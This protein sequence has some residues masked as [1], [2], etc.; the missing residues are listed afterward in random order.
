[1]PDLGG[2]RRL[3]L[4]DLDQE[5]LEGL[6]RHGEDL[7]VERK[8][9]L[10]RP[11]GFGAAAGSFANT[12]GGWILLGIADDGTVVGWEKPERLDLQSHLGNVLRAQVDPLPPF[13]AAMREVDGK[14]VAVVRVFPS[15]DLP[16]IARGTGAVHVRS[17]GGREPV[18]DH[19]TLLELARRGDDAEARARRRLAELDGVGMALRPPDF[20]PG[21]V[22]FAD[23]VDVRF[24]ARAA[25]LTVTPALA[26]WPL[27]RRAAETLAEVAGGLLPAPRMPYGR[28]DPRVEPFGRGVVVRGWQDIASDRRDSVTAVADSGGVV[29]LGV[30]RGT[31]GEGGS[32]LLNAMLEEELQP[33]ATALAGLLERAEAYGR[34]AVDLW[35]VLP[36]GA[37]IQGG[38]GG[39][40]RELKVT[41]VERELTVP[42]DA[43]EVRELALS[44][45]RQLQ[46]TA[47]VVKYEDD[48]VD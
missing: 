48:A 1:M 36:R 44:W 25:P 14:P 22:A 21:D 12:L 35:L 47:G 37:S 5:A 39:M 45:H 13:V 32:V 38:A 15:A 24:I 9:D 8:Q 16:H 4:A 3:S 6:A 7:L 10:P 42:T 27:T 46:R 20:R 29:G 41:P 33:L 43:G 31:H 26:G 11:P 40:P 18:D 28:E 34:A 19:R 17:S 2:I 23:E 30:A